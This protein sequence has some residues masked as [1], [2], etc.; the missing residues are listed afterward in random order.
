MDANNPIVKLCAQGMDEEAKRNFE[1]ATKLFKEAWEQSAS[2]FE[3][4]I[5]AHYA[6]RHEPDVEMALQWNQQALDCAHRI[7]DG[8]AAEFFPSLYLNLGK[9][10][11]D[12]GNRQTARE[13]YEIAADRLGSLPASA[14]R[15]IVED[16]IKRGLQRVAASANTD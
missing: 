6:A 11:E 7:T 3:R 14:Y 12:L 8:S 5:A 4:C 9:S 13:L 1:S 16:G 2:D 10:H 15:D